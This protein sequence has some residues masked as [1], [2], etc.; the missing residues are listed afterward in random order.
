MS[1]A[2]DKHPQPTT[3]SEGHGHVNGSVN[4]S[5]PSANADLEPSAAQEKAEKERLEI[6]I[7]S[8]ALAEPSEKSEKPDKKPDGK[9]EKP[10]REPHKK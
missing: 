6:L 2:T 8:P 10:D 9:S 3:G 7:E 5:R 1:Q 4:G